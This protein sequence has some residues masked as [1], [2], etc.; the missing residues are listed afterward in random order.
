MMILRHRSSI[1]S[2]SHLFVLFRQCHVLEVEGLDRRDMLGG[3]PSGC[4]LDLD[5]GSRGWLGKDNTTL[6][7]HSGWDWVVSNDGN[8]S[9][10]S[11]CLIYGR[12]RPTPFPIKIGWLQR[13]ST[14]DGTA[15]DG[16]CRREREMQSSSV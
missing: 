2:Y 4:L 14:S 10:S 7:G 5:L 11:C 1:A 15:R 12:D 13:W 9:A 8:M 16:D 3:G 6:H